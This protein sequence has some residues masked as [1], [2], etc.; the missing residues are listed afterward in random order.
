MAFLPFERSFS[1][2]NSI[3]SIILV[4]TFCFRNSLSSVMK[5][6]SYVSVQHIARFKT[7]IDQRLSLPESQ[8]LFQVKLIAS[9]QIL[10]LA[11][12]S[13]PRKLQDLACSLVESLRFE[14]ELSG[15][16]LTEIMILLSRTS[17]IS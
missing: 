10:Q 15:D 16:Q 12:S 7:I 5:I 4:V 3:V 2:H 9:L 14:S 17:K 13:A 8:H 1:F 11:S 6:M